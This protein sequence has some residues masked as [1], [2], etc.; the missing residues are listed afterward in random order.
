MTIALATCSELPHGDAD[1]APLPGLLGGAQ[2][3][4]WDDPAVDWGAFDL[5]V[6]RSTWDYQRR[7]DE[8][9]DWARGVPR[10]VNPAA[11]LEW[12]TDKRY[13]AELAASGLAVVDTTFVEPGE[14]FAAPE[15]REYVVKPSVSAG[16][17]DTARFGPADHERARALVERIHSS[18]RTAMVQPYLESV[19]ERG[20]TALMFF[21]GE[22]SHT[23]TKGPILRPGAEPTPDL[24]AAEEVAA[25]GPTPGELDLGFLVI[26]HLGSLA[27][28][29]IDLVH[30]AGG[31]PA[32]LEVE[33]TEPSLFFA[34]APGAAQRFADALLG[35]T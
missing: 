30:D 3:A 23:I 9:L 31:R 7:R 21:G 13:L 35:S 33:L 22:Y 5:V 12:N 17:R 20:E 16:S 28:A 34:H 18:G 24:F 1:D 2:W 8:F 25:R 32:V 15:G 11:V 26:E 4:V 19:D 6:V 14:P 29:R 27:Y 10:L